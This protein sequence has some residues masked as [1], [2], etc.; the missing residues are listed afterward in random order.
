[1]WADELADACEGAWRAGADHQ[2]AV[3]LTERGVPE[4]EPGVGLGVL[5]DLSYPAGFAEWARVKLWEESCILVVRSWTGQVVSFQMRHPAIKN[6]IKFEVFD[7]STTPHLWGA[8]RAL[9]PLWAS[10]HLVLAEGPFDALACRLAGAGAAVATLGAMASRVTQRWV[11]RL[12]KR[13]TILY[14]MDAPGR[15][16]AA[17]LAST[18]TAAG[19]VVSTPA[20]AAHDPWDLWRSRPDAL[21]ALTR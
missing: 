1:V 8:E 15:Q 2:A 16:A 20:Y 7:G 9:E 19:L 11:V 14:D 5:P 13:L 3:W 21:R 18:F 6:Y 12:A 17:R 4:R 10:R